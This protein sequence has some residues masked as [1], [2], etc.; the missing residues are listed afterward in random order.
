MRVFIIDANHQPL[1]PTTPRRAR[2]LLNSG[3]AAVYRRFPFTLIL[4]REVEPFM[5]PPLR[6]KLDPGSRTTGMTVVNDATGEVVFAAEIEH[7]GEVVRQKLA[8]RRA[9]RRNR[10]QRQTRYRK[11]K[12]ANRRLKIGW[13]PPSLKSR[14]TNILTWT[15]RIRRYCPVSAITLELVKFDTQLMQNASVEGI[16]YQQGELAG[17]ELREFLLEKFNRRCAYCGQQNVPLQVEHIVPRA[18]G[19]SNRVSN[20][21]IACQPC[22][23]R[24]GTQT[25]EEFGFPEVQTQVKQPL[26]DAAAVNTTR[27]E[28]F[29]RLQTI[30]LPLET[31]SGGLTKYNRTQRGLQK[32]HWQDAACTGASTPQHLLV[33]E[34][35]PLLITATGRGSRQMCGTDRFGFPV[36]HR[37]RNKTVRGFQTGDMVR[38]VVPSGRKTSG[39]HFGRVLVRAS[40]SFD[41]RTRAG[42][43]GGINA[44]Y[45]TTIHRNDGYQYCFQK[46]TARPIQA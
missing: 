5:V 16:E 23:Q 28:L 44:R 31:G 40:G 33:D 41:L 30:G 13:M 6:I 12:F 4:K 37:T 19:G 20:L 26:K 18:R 45:C 46:P 2:K 38:A 17:Y 42:R 24:K 9:Q 1:A 8:A 29:Q 27:W 14:L 21:T 7:R 36:R 11:A 39:V 25:A 35:N 22:N 43:I 10:R 34:V 15:E 32:G 3:K